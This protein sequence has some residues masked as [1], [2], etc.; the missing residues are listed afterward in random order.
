MNVLTSYVRCCLAFA[1]WAGASLMSQAFA[2][3]QAPLTGQ[4]MDGTNSTS[5]AAT[6]TTT[7][8]QTTASAPVAQAQPNVANGH[9]SE[10]T[11]TS[12]GETTRRLL[13]LQASGS[14]AGRRLPML[15]DQASAAYVRYLK[16]FEHPIPEFY[17]TS[18]GK[19][20]GNGGGSGISQ[21]Q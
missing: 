21:G 19:S 14:V 20:G 11:Q 7:A 16:S 5:T 1:V 4:M 6:P 13:E 18:V 9:D 8:P 12:V 2:A 10:D 3:Q 15:G 17:E